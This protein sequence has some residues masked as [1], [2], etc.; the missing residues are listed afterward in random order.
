MCVYIYVRIIPTGVQSGLLSNLFEPVYIATT[1]VGRKYSAKTAQRGLCCRS[2]TFTFTSP[3]ASMYAHSSSRSRAYDVRSGGGSG[4]VRS[5]GGSG[6]G[7]SGGDSG[8]V[9]S[10]GGSGDVRSGGGSGDVRSG[11][12]SGDVRLGGGSGDACDELKCGTCDSTMPSIP[13]VSIQQDRQK[14]RAYLH[15]S[16]VVV[17][18]YRVNH[19]AILCTAVK[20]DE[21]CITTST[22]PPP[23]AAATPPPASTPTPSNT[24]S[25]QPINSRR[26][27]LGQLDNT[28]AA[29][30][31]AQFDESRCLAW[32]NG[33]DSHTERNL[34]YTNNIE[35]SELDMHIIDGNTGLA[36]NSTGLSYIS[37][38]SSSAL[39]TRYIHSISLL[40]S[41]PTTHSSTSIPTHIHHC[42]INGSLPYTIY[43]RSIEAGVYCHMYSQYKQEW[44]SYMSSAVCKQPI[45]AV[46][47]D[48]ARFFRD[49][50]MSAV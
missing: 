27:G 17:P 42:S 6:G 34:F 18:S 35:S 20:F 31:G 19:P 10:G 4:D 47:V 14:D 43:K 5:G 32:W 25:V 38:L 9:R 33:F 8:D 2:N 24:T 15:I 12:G 13:A 7:R 36:V 1:T 39:Y 44:L 49:L 28:P 3:Q 29:Q 26:L 37:E 50:H 11:G 22:S 16:A 23:A 46:W 40:Q 45:E 21:G 48:K 30:V 41:L